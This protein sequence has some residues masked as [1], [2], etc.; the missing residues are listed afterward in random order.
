MWSEEEMAM[1]RVDWTGRETGSEKFSCER[2][3]IWTSSF[4]LGLRGESVM[5]L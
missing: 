3:G 1:V 4:S 2:W 5:L